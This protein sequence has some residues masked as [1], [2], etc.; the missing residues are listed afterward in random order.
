MKAEV[1]VYVYMEVKE[2]ARGRP[3]I[4]FID[5]EVFSLVSWHFEDLGIDFLVDFYFFEINCK[6]KALW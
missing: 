3:G 5:E 6:A 4:F 1:V 2:N